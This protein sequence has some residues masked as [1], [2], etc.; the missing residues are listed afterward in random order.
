MLERNILYVHFFNHRLH[1]VL[2]KTIPET[3]ILKHFFEQCIIIIVHNFFHYGKVAALHE[4]KNY[5]LPVGAMLVRTLYDYK[6]NFFKLCRN[7]K[8]F[9]RHIGKKIFAKFT[10]EL[11]EEFLFSQSE[12]VFLGCF[13]VI[14]KSFSF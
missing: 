3:V 1:L 10:L 12:F 11:L 4:G 7:N 9:K 5:C 14:I 8:T 6:C 13:S 2:I